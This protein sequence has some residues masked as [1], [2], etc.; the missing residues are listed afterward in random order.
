MSTAPFSL[1]DQKILVPAIGASFKKLDPRRI[2]RQ[3]ETDH[4]AR[5]GVQ[6]QSL[7]RDVGRE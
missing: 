5:A 2:P 3:L 7:A 1:F 6:V 4:P